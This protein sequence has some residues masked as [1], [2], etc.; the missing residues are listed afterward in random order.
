MDLEFRAG[1]GEFLWRDGLELLREFLPA[2]FT[3]L[4]RFLRSRVI[5]AN[6][7]FPHER[8]RLTQPLVHF[9][10]F[11]ILLY[12]AAERKRLVGGQFAEEQRCQLKLKLSARIFGEIRI[13]GTSPFLASSSAIA[14]SAWCSR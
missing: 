5:L 10:Q 13:H 12:G 1:P 8:D 4:K 11:R 6:L 2:A 9:F 3:Q 7:N 14:F